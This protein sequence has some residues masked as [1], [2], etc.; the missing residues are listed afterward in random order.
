MFESN[1]TLTVPAVAV[2]VAKAATIDAANILL[3]GL[4]FGPEFLAFSMIDNKQGMC[5]ECL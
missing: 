4:I 3:I 2:P 5:H 1:V